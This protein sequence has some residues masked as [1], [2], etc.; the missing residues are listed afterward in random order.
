MKKY[1]D[2]FLFS[3][4]RANSFDSIFFFQVLTS[5]KILASLGPNGT[6][7]HI[8]ICLTILGLNKFLV[9]SA[10]DKTSIS[11]TNYVSD[12]SESKHPLPI[13]FEDTYQFGLL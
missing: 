10:T 12:T 1:T 9:K 3:N 6:K 11:V 8:E 13:V 2:L 7:G 5:A 4:S